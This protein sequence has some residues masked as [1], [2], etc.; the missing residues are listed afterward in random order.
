VE[1]HGVK[2]E[3]Q[4]IS[5]HNTSIEWWDTTSSSKSQISRTPS[6]SA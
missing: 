5:R 4:L 3:R 1:R 2:H 6:A